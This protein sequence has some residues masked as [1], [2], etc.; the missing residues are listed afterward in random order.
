MT[1]FPVS[2]STLS[3]PHLALYLQEKYGFDKNATCKIF[4]TGI[5]HTYMVTDRATRYVFRVYSHQWRTA[6]E[7]AEE[8]RLLD[9]LRE[10]GISVSYPIKDNTQSYIQE[11]L[12]PEGM[13]YGVLFSF[14]EGK[15]IRNL[16]ENNCQTLGALMAR[17]HQDT[18]NL[19]LER[20]D[21]T[22]QE[23]AVQPYLYAKKYYDESLE[24]MQFVKKAGGYLAALFTQADTSQLRKGGV[25]LDLW[26]DNMNIT[27][28]GVIT[29]FDFDFCGNGWLV[30]DVAYF[31]V[32][33]FNT[34]P[35]KE[36]YVAKVAAFYGGYESLTPLSDEEKRL[37][38][39]V[40]LAIWIFYLGVQAQ[41]FDNW[42]NIFLTENYLKHFI[43]LIDNW[44]DYNGIQIAA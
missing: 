3:A 12:A 37:I 33:L 1:S 7:I 23:L 42:S 17:M 13:R 38:P 9:L 18:L 21:Y 32:Q 39:H 14:A 6:V 2:D 35:D 16:D 11:I 29:L 31:A 28:E 41:R 40:G 19:R 5:N 15:K 27:G 24:E 34:E 26:Y 44:L 20:V 36:I 4:R 25:H 30:L 8:L 43:G 22:I 10:N